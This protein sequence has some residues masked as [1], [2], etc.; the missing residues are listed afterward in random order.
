MFISRRETKYFKNTNDYNVR[1]ER[2]ER[3]L[4]FSKKEKRPW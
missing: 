3:I 4:C 1:E 2:L